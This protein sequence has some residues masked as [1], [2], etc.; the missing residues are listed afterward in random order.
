MLAR[1]IVRRC[2]WLVV[3]SLV[4][5]AARSVA[6]YDP[7]VDWFTLQSPRLEV[8]YR[9]GHYQTALRVARLGEVA[10]EHLA[11]RLGWQPSLPVHVVLNEDTDLANGFARSLPYNVVGLNNVA[12]AELSTL[13][14]YDDWLYLLLAHELAHVVHL[15]TVRGLPRILNGI[16]G[17]WLVPNGVQP[18]WMVEGLATYFESA[19]SSAGRVRA[20]YTDMVL[21]TAVLSERAMDLGQVSGFPWAWPQGNVPYLYGGRFVDYLVERFGERALGQLS[22]DYGARLIPFGVNLSAQR[23]IGEPYEQLYADFLA[24]LEQHY[25]QQRRQI[26]AA[27]IRT[28]TRF[29][30]RGQQVGPARVAADG[31]IYFVESPIG[32][33]TL[34][35]AIDADGQT[36]TIQRL[37][38]GAQLALLPG[39]K[40]ALVAQVEVSDVYRTYGDL[41]A[42]ELPGGGL[43][44]VTHGWRAREPDVSSD[45]RWLVVAR[46]QGQKSTLWLAKVD[47][48]HRASLLADLGPDTQ[49]WAPRFSPSA[50]AVVFAASAEGQRDLYMVDRRSG[51][52]R[53]LTNDRALDGGPTFS[54]NGRHVFFH[55]DRDGVFNLYAIPV[56]GGDARQLT[57]VVTGAFHPE[58]APDGET[59]IYRHYGVEGYDLSRLTLPSL[60]RLP[61][62][63]NS[64]LVRQPAVRHR[65]QALYPGRPYR[66]LQ[67]LAPRGWLPISG[68]DTRGSVWGVL[69]Q[70]ADPVALHSYVAQLWWGVTSRRPGFQLTYRNAQFHPGLSLDASRQLAYAPVAHVR[71]DTARGIEQDLWRG[72]LSQSWPLLVS[73]DRSL[74]LS[75]NYEL[76]VRRH[77]TSLAVAPLDVAPTRPD[78]GRFASVGAQ[79]H[80]SSVRRYLSSISSEEGLRAHLGVRWEGPWWGSQFRS[81]SSTAGLTIYQELPWWSRHVAVFDSFAGYGRSNYRRNKLFGIAGLPQRD[82]LLDAVQGRLSGGRALRGFPL[83]PLVGDALLSATLEYRLPL[84][85]IERGIS[86]LPVYFQSLHAALFVDAAAVANRPAELAEGRHASLGAEARLGLVLGYGLPVTARVGYGRGV[87]A[88][89]DLQ[90]FFFVLGTIL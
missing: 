3:A 57:R 61:A 23:V 20:S 27:G 76:V 5:V 32:D 70:G 35:Q 89:S 83:V 68:L 4:L 15:D 77:V 28:G 9:A 51:Q 42:L 7:R 86:T 79:L 22:Y 21:R 65:P 78:E 88:D 37:Q 82:L 11:A 56:D 75:Y 26:I 2:R 24:E 10:F 64:S 55:A 13:S 54:A 30:T 69:V 85:D 6:A 46:D 44:R 49:V 72:R 50:E 41:F 39:G 25:E 31:T 18:R 47:D 53:R 67:T 62:A 66:S 12:P 73:R 14:D 1:R 34:L 87:G 40:Q 81:I 36:R 58:P 19:L 33:H 63:A 8:H 43:E 38:R 60:D 48:P 17:R 59:L 84:L 52:L 16:F 74:R 80:Y 71:N 29:T 45:G 90:S